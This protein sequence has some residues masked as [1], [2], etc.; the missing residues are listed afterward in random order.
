MEYFQHFEPTDEYCDELARFHDWL[1]WGTPA[2][3]SPRLP[4]VSRSALDERLRVDQECLELI[5]RVRQR[6]GDSLAPLL[7]QRCQA[8]LSCNQG[9]VVRDNG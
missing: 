8:D 6:C 4:S 1:L 3:P 9:V 5:E 7:R 2:E